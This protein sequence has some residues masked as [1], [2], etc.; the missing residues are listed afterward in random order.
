LWTNRGLVFDE[1]GRL[2][3]AQSAGIDITRRKQ[4]EEALQESDRRKDEFLATLAHELRSPLAPIGNAVE[5]LR[6]AGD[7][8][9]LRDQAR[10]AIERQLTHLVRLVDDLLD[11]SR[12][13]KDRLE[14]R[15]SR[16]DL[17]SAIDHAL[18][19]CCPHLERDR[20]TIEVTLPDPPI[21]LEA[22]PVRLAQIFNNLLNNACKYTAPEGTIRLTAERQD[23]EAVVT[24]RDRGIGIPHEKLHAIFD[25]FTQVQDPNPQAIGGLGIGL[26]LVKRLVELHGGS[27]CARSDGRDC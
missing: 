23:G 8:P 17:S 6:Q 26:T 7:D 19:T 14:L 24:I 27:V 20:Q 2:L 16:V 10:E 21:Y 12:I 13:T 3:E 5:I 25:M 22:D 9:A 15:K 1:N 11:V 4:M 18:E